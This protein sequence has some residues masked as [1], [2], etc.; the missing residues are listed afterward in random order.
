MLI[1]RP[2]TE[3]G[4]GRPQTIICYGVCSMAINNANAPVDIAE[5]E[6][7]FLG[8]TSSAI[9]RYFAAFL[10][11]A[12]AT[13]IAVGADMQVAIPNLS[14]IFVVP[15]IVSGVSLGLGP[16]LL[17][18][19][20][21][22]LSFD[23]FLAAPRYSLAI[24]DPANIW[25]MCLLFVVGLIASTVSFTSQRR[26]EEAARLKK[27]FMVLQRY[28]REV[29]AATS[30]EAVASLTSRTLTSLFGVPS[31]ALIVAHEKTIAVRTAGALEPNE[32]E[33]E[34]ARSSLSTGDVARGGVY[35]DVASRFD[36]L[37]IN[38]RK[39]AS[40]VLGIAFDAD[41]RPS[42]VEASVAIIARILTW[43]LE[44]EEILRP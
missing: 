6:I 9:A 13:V 41:N 34:T 20:L 8:P 44:R 2:L 26:A 11:T 17:S 27:Q 4:G 32:A 10:L 36:F 24:D 42:V 37:P 15:V 12:F 33:I 16:S 19:V 23:F 3:T 38:T 40:A 7:S 22:A 39:G 18:A 35:P 29:T 5:D 21:G 1:A 25:A 31:V 28:S 43:S 30:P 14:L